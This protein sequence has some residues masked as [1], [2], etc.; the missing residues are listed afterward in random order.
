MTLNDL[1]K[2]LATP[3]LGLEGFNVILVFLRGDG[4]VYR[5]PAEVFL[6]NIIKENAEEHETQLLAVPFLLPAYVG[7]QN[8]MIALPS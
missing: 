8:P 7:A 3:I 4:Q 2:A 5:L 1:Q 6:L